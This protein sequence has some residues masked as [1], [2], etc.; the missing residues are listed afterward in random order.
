MS[1]LFKLIKISFI[2]QFNI[3]KAF[4]KDKLL[5]NIG[6]IIL[7]LLVSLIL[8]ASVASIFIGLALN[9]NSSEATE[10]I[11]TTG[12]LLTSF[13]VLIITITRANQYIFKS[14]DFD[15]IGS[16]PISF[17]TII[18][19][20]IMSFLLMVYIYSAFIFIP[21]M[22][23][24]FIFGVTTVP[25]ILISIVVFLFLPLVIVAVFSGISYFLGYLIS[26]FKYKN[27]LT[28]IVSILF[29]VLIFTF[30]FQQG[31]ANIDPVAGLEDKLK[32]IYYPGYLALN[33]LL[34]NYISLLLFIF[35]S[36]FSF[37]IFTIILSKVFLRI[38]TSMLKTNNNKE[39]KLK[40]KV[41]SSVIKSLSKK[42]FKNYFSSATYVM[43]T[44]AGKIMFIVMLI[45]PMLN[46]ED[47]G[48]QPEFL[49]EFGVIIFVAL[50]T[51]TISM[52]ST[53]SSSISLEGKKIWILKTLPV[54]PKEVFISKLS[55]EYVLSFVTS[56]I[57]LIGFT[58]LLNV[59][60]IQFIILFIIIMLFS[61][62]SA[63]LGLLSNLHFPKMVWDQEVKVIKQS[64]SVLV[65]MILS[66]I[67]AAILIGITFLLAKAF[68]ITSI[69][70]LLII[71]L[72]I[73]VLIV[74]FEVL[75]LLT[76]GKK[77]YNQI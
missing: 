7:V 27:A 75:Y 71:Y 18:I 30:S 21:M 31:D 17:K 61:A 15:L 39:L 66:F 76:I 26:R 8:M 55:V 67:A 22:I 52:T 1:N 59:T 35:I 69:E 4:K 20:K 13:I 16:L 28:I 45:L 77:R 56:L 6:V 68:I 14:K 9:I 43:N 5:R 74:T 12:I 32:Y 38:N 37:T 73:L 62:H 64:L 63:L 3:N 51:I 23:V 65:N 2:Q 72:V 47:S 44:I 60:V 34:G 33:S 50:M 40:E 58:V 46:I 36:V 54:T 42:E 41:N 70:I 19:S 24:N 11:F 25:M 48:I 49:Y 57:V 10:I 53:T 29:L